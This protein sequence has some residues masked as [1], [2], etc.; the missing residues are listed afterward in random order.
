M[1]QIACEQSISRMK[2]AQY[3]REIQKLIVDKGYSRQRA[4]SVV[5]KP[6]VEYKGKNKDLDKEIEGIL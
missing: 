2:A 1:N 6:K 4:E 5:K 3:E